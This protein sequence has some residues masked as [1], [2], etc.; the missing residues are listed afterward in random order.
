MDVDFR[1]A[2]RSDVRFD[3]LI[4]I[5]DAEFDAIRDGLLDKLERVFG[6]IL[7]GR[8][9]ADVYALWREI[10]ADEVAAAERAPPRAGPAGPR[11]SRDRRPG[12]G[13]RRRRRRARAAA[14]RRCRRRRGRRRRRAGSS[15]RRCSSP[16][17]WSTRRAR[18]TSRCSPAPAPTA[19]S[20][21][22]GALP[23]ARRS[24]WMPARGA[25]RGLGTPTGE[26]P[27]PPGL[28]RL[29]LPDLLP[30]RRPR[31]RAPAAVGRDRRRRRA[32]RPRPR[33]P[34]ARRSAA[35]GRRAMRAGSA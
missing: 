31:R 6:A 3:G 8:A 21:A 20:G 13:D 15:A 35:A 5:T 32:G 18:C 12:R 25:G 17:C 24:R 26:R 19:P 29:L 27:H 33:R 11:R 1:P 28:I 4:D 22:R 7:A 23:A 2:N 34:R 10:T 9:E 16:R 14:A 30:G